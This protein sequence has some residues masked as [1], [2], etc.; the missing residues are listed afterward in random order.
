VKVSTSTTYGGAVVLNGKALYGSL[1]SV[2]APITY[3]GGKAKKAVFTY[4]SA[5]DSCLGGKSYS[6][7]II[8][9]GN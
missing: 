6:I 2:I 3:N 4:T 8:L 5:T 9:T 1:D 7:I